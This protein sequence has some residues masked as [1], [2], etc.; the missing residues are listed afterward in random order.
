MTKDLRFMVLFLAFLLGLPVAMH[1]QLPP[2]QPEQDCIN[3]LPVCSNIFVQASSY[4]GEGLNPNEIN[5]TIS[6]LG[7]GEKNDT[8]YIMTVQASGNINFSITPVNM[9]DDYDWA[10]YNLTN[11]PCSDIATNGALEVS[12]NYSGTSG[13][14]G[15]N[16]LPGA[17]NEPVIPA[18]VGETYVLNVSNFS[19]TSSGYTLDFTNST[20]TIFDIIPPAI[21]TV[22]VN[23]GSVVT[24][25]MSENIVCSSVQATDFFV[26]DTSG[27]VFPVTTVTGFNCNNGGTFEN[28]FTIDFTPALTAGEYWIFLQDTVLDNCGNVGIMNDTLTF[29]VPDQNLNPMASSDTLCLGDSISLWV[30]GQPGWSYTWYSG[31]FL[32]DSITIAP[33]ISQTYIVNATD[34]SGC[35]YSDNIDITVIQPPT[36]GFTLTPPAICI[37]DTTTVTFTGNAIAGSILSWDAPGGDVIG[38]GLTV[39]M[40]WNIPGTYNVSLDIGQAGCTYTPIIQPMIVHDIPTSTFVAPAEECLNETA[41]IVYTGTG[42]P[43]GNYY[44]EFDGPSLNVGAGQGPYSVAWNITGF[45]QLSLWVEENGCVSDTTTASV[46]INALPTLDFNDP[47]DQCLVGNDFQFTFLGDDGPLVG[48]GWD[49]GEPGLVSIQQ[50]DNVTYQTAGIKSVTLAVVDTN[51]CSNTLTKSVEVKPMPT[52]NFTNQSVCF[53]QGMPFTD[54]STSDVRSPLAQWFWDFGEGG[55]DNVQNPIYNYGDMGTYDVTL[56]AETSDGCRDTITK[57]V[58]VFDQ[59][60]AN[61]EAESICD[62]Q[63]MEFLNNSFYQ[64]EPIDFFWEFG[65]GTTSTEMD[66]DHLYPTHGIYNVG[67]TILNNFG[68]QNTYNTTVVVHPRPEPDVTIEPICMETAAVLNNNSTIPAPGVI[69]SYYWKFGDGV[70]S[71]LENPEHI[72]A[73]AGIYDLFLEATSSEGCK[74]TFMAPLIVHPLPQALFRYENG[75]EDQPLSFV[76]ISQIEEVPTGDVIQTWNWDFGDGTSASGTESPQHAYANAGE[77]SVTL[78]TISDKGCEQTLTQQVNIYET[79]AQ[80][81]TIA[82]TTCPGEPAELFGMGDAVADHIAWFESETDTVPYVQGDLFQTPKLDEAFMYYAAAV[83]EEGCESERVPVLADVFDFSLAELLQSDTLVEVPNSVV[84]FGATGIVGAQSYWWRFGDG[85]DSRESQPNYQYLTPGIFNIMLEVTT[86]AGCV[87]DL[88][89]QIEVT[90]LMNV[91]LPNAFSPNE[92]DVNDYFFLRSNLMEQIHIEIY[93][94]WGQLVFVSDNP[95]FQWDGTKMGGGQLP[96]GVYVYRVEGVDFSGADVLHSGTI[97]LIR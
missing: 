12:C 61:F 39:E 31:G 27:V 30:D 1:A 96:E 74:D 94:R 89:S 73:G 19:S 26:L 76:S 55:S 13:V 51:G 62:E 47:S 92:D 46:Y 56:I 28:E 80:P 84:A 15:A 32:G 5:S 82:D 66:P 53:G 6:C 18:L 58:T 54:L 45:K 67:L 69:A 43:A 40:T 42:T 49:F 29:T 81:E 14:T 2:N 59:P 17:Q 68:C 65:D 44:W 71:D 36:G 24:V 87:V 52:A 64:V 78:T 48:Y 38:T 50:S 93:D 23:C 77:Y 79:P 25:T 95:D 63:V 91:L 37:G 75:C 16:G 88:M 11:N 34:P 3:A 7:S 22:E 8:W 9:T 41:A 4:Q 20:A 83:S 35:T 72:Y 97:S 86:E 85:N 10:V 21:D 57:S 70:T 90:R 60:I 33:T